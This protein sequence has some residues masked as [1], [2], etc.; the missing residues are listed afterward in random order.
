MQA[1]IDNTI[2]L[3]LYGRKHSP[4]GIIWPLVTSQRQMA[5]TKYSVGFG[6]FYCIIGIHEGEKSTEL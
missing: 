6:E 1:P 5:G 4:S 3:S 2:T